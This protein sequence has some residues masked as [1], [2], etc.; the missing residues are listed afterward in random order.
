MSC[1]SSATI[2]LIMTTDTRALQRPDWVAAEMPP[3]YRNRLEELQRLSRELEELGRFGSLLCTVGSEL[4]EAV[5]DT[6]V[7]LELDAVTAPGQHD[8][9]IIVN[10]DAQRRLLLHVSASDQVVQ[11]RSQDLA[12]VFQIIHEQA[13]TGDR[14]VLIAN[15]SPTVPPAQ[16]GDG[17]DA[18]ALSLLKR[19]GAN[20][21]AG[22]TLFALWSL[23]LQ[24][25]PRARAT[26]DRI[27]AQD[28]GVFVMPVL[29]GV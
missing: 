11:R 2:R 5:R 25:R 20:Y 27:H 12:H 26:F 9:S 6:L 8:S 10:L 21:L 18:E 22:P 17:V 15:H 14:V 4:S 7:A 3:G 24:D 29:V 28:G 1:H 16:R 13:G 23:S 19:L